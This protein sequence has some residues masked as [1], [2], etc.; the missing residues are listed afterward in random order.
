M[1]KYVLP[2]ILITNISCYKH[3]SLVEECINACQ[4]AYGTKMHELNK[5]TCICENH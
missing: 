5:R 4:M 1:I 3:E 2:F